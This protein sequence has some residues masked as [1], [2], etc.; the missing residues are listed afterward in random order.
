MIEE[1]MQISDSL[2]ALFGQLLC[3]TLSK[4]PHTVIV[5]TRGAKFTEALLIKKMKS[6]IT[7]ICIILPVRF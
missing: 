3:G 5:T 2:S 7:F 4:L 6:C 1:S